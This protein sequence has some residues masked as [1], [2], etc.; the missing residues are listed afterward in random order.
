MGSPL[1]SVLVEMFL[2]ELE[3]SLLPGLTKYINS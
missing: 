1:G 2:I 3:N